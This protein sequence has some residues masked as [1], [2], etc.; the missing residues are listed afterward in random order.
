[1]KRVYLIR[2]ED[3]DFNILDEFIVPSMV[4]AEQICEKKE[5]ALND[6]TF[7]NWSELIEYEEGDTYEECN[8]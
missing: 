4:Q 8:P 3:T 1:M 2:H 7:W 6:N 5:E